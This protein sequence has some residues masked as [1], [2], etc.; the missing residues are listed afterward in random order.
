MQGVDWTDDLYQKPIPGKSAQ[1]VMK[2]CSGKFTPLK[3]WMYFDAEEALPGN[4]A[5]PLPA[6]ETAPRGSRYDAQACVLGWKT[7]EQLGRL[8]Y[9]L[10]GAGAI[11]CEM[12]K[13]W[14]MMGL[15]AG[16]GGKVVVTD[17]DTIEKSNLNRQF[18]FRP[19]D[20][21]KAKSET[22][23]AAIQQMNPQMAIEAQL[24]RVG[25][26]TEDIFD[27]DFWEALSGVCNALDNVQAR[28]YVDQRCI[29][30]QKSLLESG[31]LGAKGNVQLVVPRMTESYGSS[32]DP[33]EKSIP[34]CTLKNFPNEISHCIQWSRDIFEGLF[35]QSGED[36]NA[37]LSQPDFLT[38]LERQPGVR[39][40]TLK[41]I[42]A[43]LV[44]KPLTLEACV[45]WSRLK[46]EELFSNSIAQLLYNF[47]LDMTTSSGAPFWSGPKRPPQIAAFSAD[48]PLHM[49]FIVA[50]ANLR[51]QN[52]GL[53]GST[54]IEFM[55]R[56][57]ESVMVPEFVPQQGVKIVSDPKEEEKLKEQG[58]APA[59][60]ADD[61]DAVCDGIIK[62]LPAP[63]SLAGYRMVPA[64][65]EKDDDS[66][67]HVDF[68]TACSNLRARNYKIGEAD[69][70]KTKHRGQDHP[71]HRHHHR[72]GHRPRVRRAAQAAAARQEDRGLQERLLQP[73]AALRLLL[74]AD[75][76]AQE[77]G[78]RERDGVDPLGPLRHR[79]GPRADPEG[80]HRPVQGE[81]QAGGDD[82][83]E[84]REHPLLVLHQPEEAQGALPDEDVGASARRLQ[85]RVQAQAKVPHVRDLLQR[86]ERGR[87]RRRGGRRGAVCQ[88][89]IRLLRRPLGH[90][91]TRRGSRACRCRQL[92]DGWL[93]PYIKARTC[94]VVTFGTSTC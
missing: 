87:R 27:D 77:A 93:L 5:E 67:H 12:V 43:N 22:A 76:R 50:A 6:A 3:Q 61:D 14:A 16:E 59:P 94:N 39:R 18:L 34:V 88:V 11:G 42:H 84:R 1:E 80:V 70:H 58:G 26:E 25:P 19:W 49:D 68:I 24:N 90:E 91:R 31:T 32:R 53:K 21:S 38:A 15:G 71:R 47:P 33:P 2:A 51:A 79:R 66:N 62:S 48:D 75:R 10:V 82:D 81:V 17:P 56:A 83:L 7:Q 23:A 35:K 41:E 54:D 28:L 78:G 85:D 44:E 46:F 60:T 30:Y 89:S 64:E 13:N 45:V 8:Q 92:V 65:F 40:T 9:L 55:K 4:G 36:V 52:Y 73:R 63:S 29:Y 20:V 72:D 37:Y 57:A 69:R 74:R 86:H